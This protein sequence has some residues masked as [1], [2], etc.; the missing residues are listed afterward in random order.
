MRTPSN[1]PD[2]KRVILHAIQYWGEATE[3]QIKAYC[4]LFWNGTEYV[5]DDILVNQ[6]LE[7]KNNGRII[8]V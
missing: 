4:K 2:I 3:D 6:L 1:M 8:S 7:Q 5:F